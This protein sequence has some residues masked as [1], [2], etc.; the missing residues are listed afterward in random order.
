[1]VGTTDTFFDGSPD[2][3]EST[4]EDVEYLLET[5]NAYA[6]GA[7]LVPDD[8]LSTWAGLRPL[9]KPSRNEAGASEVSREHMLYE[10]PGFITIAGGKLT[11]YRRMAAEVVDRAVKQLGLDAKS[12]TIDRPL[13]GAQGLTE[14]D[15]ALLAVAKV[16]EAQGLSHMTADSFATTY[17]A[18]ATQV[19]ARTRADPTASER[20][21]GELPYLLAQ[22]DEAVEVELA[23]TLDDVLSRRIQLSLR[24]RDQGLGV[25]RKVA[26]RM[27]GLLDWSAER[28][29]QELE[30]FQRV[31]ASS[32][33]FRRG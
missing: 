31:I 29:E 5:A 6:P 20:L 11:T 2:Q 14:S 1:M 7:R 32:R 23:R 21:D 24:G 25:A 3:V 15:D 18:R 17:G 26:Q 16:L 19:L 28:I 9:L 4:A 22:V 10:R 30:H 8:V 27:A 33:A 12:A 13:P